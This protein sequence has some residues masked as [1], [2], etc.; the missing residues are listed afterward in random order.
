MI[1]C[2]SVWHSPKVTQHN[3][4]LLATI[5]DVHGDVGWKSHSFVNHCPSAREEGISFLWRPFIFQC[6]DDAGQCVAAQFYSQAV[7]PRKLE[8]KLLLVY[9][10]HEDCIWHSTDQCTCV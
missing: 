3:V 1:L 2:Q 5:T 9:W 10:V 6:A 4:G 8:K 7:R